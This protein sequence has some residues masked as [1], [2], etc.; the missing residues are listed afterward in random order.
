LSIS[1]N[2]SSVDWYKASG[3][4]DFSIIASLNCI[5]G[6]DGVFNLAKRGAELMNW[7]NSPT[8]A[9]F[10]YYV[11]TVYTLSSH[12]SGN[13]ILRPAFQFFE[14]TDHD[15]WSPF[16]KSISGVAVD[17]IYNLLTFWHAD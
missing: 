16:L 13:R 11:G 17:T 1:S 4:V 3:E 7:E 5:H 15:S 8:T 14:K 2:V 10:V 6:S 9:G 12:I